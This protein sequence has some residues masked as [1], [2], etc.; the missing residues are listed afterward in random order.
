[1]CPSYFCRGGRQETLRNRSFDELLRLGIGHG[2][3]CII[4][5]GNRT[6]LVAESGQWGGLGIGEAGGEVGK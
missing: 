2:S 6:R 4:S 1:M 5:D 3:E